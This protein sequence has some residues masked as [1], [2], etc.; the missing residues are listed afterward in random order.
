MNIILLIKEIGQ[1]S[2][3]EA[4]MHLAPMMPTKSILINIDSLK[5]LQF[6]R[7]KS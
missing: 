7:G 3:K 2:L 6:F 4:L 1:D 5:I